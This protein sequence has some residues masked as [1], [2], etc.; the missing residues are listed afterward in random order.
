MRKNTAFLPPGSPGSGPVAAPKKI[1]GDLALRWPGLPPVARRIGHVLGFRFGRG[2]G[3]LRPNGFPVP[4]NNFPDVSPKL[5][6]EPLPI[7]CRRGAR[8]AARVQ[9]R[10]RALTI[11][12]AVE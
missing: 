5:R 4:G 9:G 7:H 10:L 11:P 3:H 1:P 8:H 6:G 2:T 12:V